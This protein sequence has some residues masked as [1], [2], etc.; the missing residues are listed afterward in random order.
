MA[1]TG[2]AVAPRDALAQWVI[3]HGKNGHTEKGIPV[4]TVK[5]LKDLAKKGA[6]FNSIAFSP[7]GGWIILHDRYAM[8]ARNAP[9][10]AVKGLAEQQ[11]K[12]V[13]LKSIAFTF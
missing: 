10:E 2:F 13:E 11:A 3:L 1:T 8:F 7:N 5:T 6:Q 4:E 9:K 12:Q